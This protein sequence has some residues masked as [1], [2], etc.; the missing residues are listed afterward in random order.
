MH[1]RILLRTHY[2]ANE[3]RL[4]IAAVTKCSSPTARR[5]EESLSKALE[6]WARS[7]GYTISTPGATYAVGNARH[8][9]LLTNNNN[10]TAS[11][12]SLAFADHALPSDSGPESRLLTPLEERLYLTIYLTGAGALVV[13][14]ADWLIKHGPVTNRELR[15][16]A[17]LENRMHEALDEYLTLATEIRDRTA[18]RSERDRLARTEYAASTKRH[19][20]YPL[21]TTM[22]RLRLLRSTDDESDE[23]TI[24]PDSGGRLAAFSR[25]IPDVKT[26]E[27]CARD[28]TLRRVL[29]IALQEYARPDLPDLGEPGGVIAD[30][31]QFAMERGLQA[32]PLSFLDDVLGA[33]FPASP[34]GDSMKSEQL[35]G[36]IQRDRPGEVR[37]HVNRR[38]QR[39]FVLLAKAAI[40]QIATRAVAAKKS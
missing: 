7:N 14:F 22:Q 9:G 32:C 30:A 28:N 37:F 17:I 19:K 21:L 16:E 23:S 38:G 6:K 24:V 35:L 2:Q 12:L 33:L 4:I 27:R 10:W 5:G 31:Y 15:E 3:P 25:A 26:L 20:R 39:A 40:D 8:L 18:I 29:D 11:G 13:K 36:P 1:P 34:T